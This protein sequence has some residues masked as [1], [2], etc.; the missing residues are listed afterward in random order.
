M[1][2][3]N[4]TKKDKEYLAHIGA[5]ERDIKQIEITRFEYIFYGKKGERKVTEE[6]AIRLVGRKPV[7]TGLDRAT[8][9]ASAVRTNNNY[10]KQIMIVSDTFD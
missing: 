3:F 5:S 8:F 10:S 4:L 7:L 2:T 9:H 1:K 6:E